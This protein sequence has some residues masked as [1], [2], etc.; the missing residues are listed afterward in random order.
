MAA[1]DL[2]IKPIPAKHANA[3][4]RR[5]HYSGKVVPNSQLHF[6]VFYNNRLEGAMQLGPPINKKG[7]I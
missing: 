4:I 2:I 6:G 7:S 5:L 3:L 1:K